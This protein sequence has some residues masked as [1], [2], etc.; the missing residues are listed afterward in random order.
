MVNRRT[1]ITQAGIGG[2]A[3][4]IAARTSPTIASDTKTL[5]IGQLGLGG[6]NF[7]LHFAR[8]RT[9]GKDG[10]VLV[11]YGVWDDEP[12]VAVRFAKKGFEK[13]CASPE[14]LVSE[15]DVVCIEHGDY[16][17]TLELA[18]P[19]LEAGTP[20]FIDRPF[21]DTVG[22]A[23]EIVRLARKHKTPLMCCS[24]LELQPFIPEIK[25]WASE[26]GPVK[27]YVCSCPEPLFHWMFPHVINFAHAALGGG[28][29]SA[30]FSGDFI[31][32]MGKIR[33]DGKRWVDEGRP[34]GSAVSILTYKSRNGQPPITGINHIGPGPGPYH[35]TVNCEHGRKDFVAGERLDDP[36]IFRPM[37]DTLRSFFTTGVPPRPYEAI[38]EQH[39][40][41]VATAVSHERGR[42][43][44]LDSLTDNDRLP[45]S[46]SVRDW[47][48]WRVLR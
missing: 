17:K 23:E 36:V 8:T 24:S 35:I 40:A 27:S 13:V 10:R 22:S 15:S 34:L 32:E 33:S 7:A 1:F 37:T 28:M 3:G 31:I 16:R 25:K 2:I 41:H 44:R 18:R 29:E 30:Y 42:A 46:D 19:A 12:D 5:R 6:H 4:I 43:V 45:Y 38:L 39:R 48:K 21:T 9:A 47:L 11:P 26:N 14:E 20:V